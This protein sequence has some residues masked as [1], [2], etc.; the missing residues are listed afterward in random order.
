MQLLNLSRLR[1]STLPSD[2][3]A[4]YAKAKLSGETDEDHAEAVLT[5]TLLSCSDLANLS[6]NGTAILGSALFDGAEIGSDGGSSGYENEWDA[7]VELLRLILALPESVVV[8][9]ANK[10]SDVAPHIVM[11]T[12]MDHSLDCCA[13]GG[14][15]D[16]YDDECA[17]GCESPFVID[18][19]SILLVLLSSASVRLTASDIRQAMASSTDPKIR[20]RRASSVAMECIGLYQRLVHCLGR[21]NRRRR[22]RVSNSNSE[23]CSALI[24]ATNLLSKYVAGAII[25]LL[26]VFQ[27]NN[28][29]TPVEKI[30]AGL[31]SATSMTS[32]LINT[33]LAQH[34]PMLC[35]QLSLDLVASCISPLCSAQIDTVLLNPLRQWDY[36]Q[37]YSFGDADDDSLD[38]GEGSDADARSPDDMLADMVCA[39]ASTDNAGGMKTHWDSAGIAFL[40]HHI[41]LGRAMLPSVYSP[42]FYFVMLY[43][44]SGVLFHLGQNDDEQ[45]EGEA[46]FA[47]ISNGIELL[48]LTLDLSNDS[49][50]TNDSVP[51]AQIS[52]D[53]ESPLGPVGSIQLLLNTAMALPDTDGGFSNGIGECQNGQGNISKSKILRLIRKLLTCYPPLQHVR[54]VASLLQRCPFDSLKPVLLDLLRPALLQAADANTEDDAVEGET[55]DL[56]ENTLGQMRSHIATSGANKNVRSSGTRLVDLNGLMSKVEQYTCTVSLVRLILIRQEGKIKELEVKS[57]ARLESAVHALF[58]FYGGLC[59]ILDDVSSTNLFFQ[60]H[61]LADALGE[62]ERQSTRGSDKTS[63]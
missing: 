54:S 10:R 46:R 36:D 55:L 37:V 2:L 58:D 23:E 41:V 29:V 25:D 49:V 44:H 50:P 34:D 42:D 35:H 28:S 52:R 40:A 32:R 14:D 16:G 26:A 9:N 6:P 56:L 17:G 18:T 51:Y 33:F 62:L 63:V 19:K 48:G 24:D 43:P 27:E 60:L 5:E 45:L 12:V 4:A 53:V 1:M 31:I 15:D 39:H 59:E 57:D 38:D 20:W 3:L 13:Y 7:C 21:N 30:E 47:I 61:L 22:G 8:G 11:R